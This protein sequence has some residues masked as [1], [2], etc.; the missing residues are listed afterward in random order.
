MPELA[1]EV[2][3]RLSTT[4]TISLCQLTQC[5]GVSHS[6]TYRMIK[7]IAYPYKFSICHEL[8]PGDG[9]RCVEFCHWILDF[10]SNENVF[11][12]CYFSDETRFYLSGYINAQ[13]FRTWSATNLYQFTE[14]PLHPQK[15]SVFCAMSRKEI[16]GP[17]FF[18]TTLNLDRYVD[19][20]LNFISQLGRHEGK[21]FFIN[22]F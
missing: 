15:I 18:T 21:C 4:P 9:A 20:M 19:S 16:V 6:S 17:F 14:S 5:I 22:F 13:N 3:E 1:E 10:A 2:R 8:K 7:S 12:K 11:N